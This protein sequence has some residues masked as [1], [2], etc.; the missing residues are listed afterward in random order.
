MLVEIIHCRQVEARR[1]EIAANAKGRLAAYRAGEL[2]AKS[3]GLVI[4]ELH[5]ALEDDE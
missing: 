2:E 1:A 3:A 4:R 5:Q